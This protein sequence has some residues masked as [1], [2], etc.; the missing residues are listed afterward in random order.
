MRVQTNQSNRI[1]N[2]IRMKELKDLIHLEEPGWNLVQGWLNDAK[3]QCE[4]LPKDSRRAN[5]ELVNAQVTTR[6]S[7]G[8]VIYETG[9]ILIDYGWIRILGSGSCK[10]DRGLAEWNKDKILKNL[11]DVSDFLL[12][13]DDVIGGFFAVNAGRFGEDIGKIYYLAQDTLEWENLGCGYSGFLNWAFNGDIPLFYNGFRW[14]TWKIDIEKLNGN[15]VFSFFPFLWTEQGQNI[16][17]V[18]RGIIPIEEHYHFTIQM[19]DQ[20]I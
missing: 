11:G 1:I 13:A 8:S 6:S 10:L 7:M 12:I 17:T 4:V 3:N 2:Q 9:G 20:N 15:E 18:Q 16:G 19:Q 5:K 14:K